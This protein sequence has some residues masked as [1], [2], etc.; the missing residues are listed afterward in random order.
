MNR[1]CRYCTPPERHPGCHATCEEYLREKKKY[2]YD[3]REMSDKKKIAYD[4]DSY[5]IGRFDR[6]TKKNKKRR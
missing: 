2:D 1:C 5:E 6:I 3:K 4:M